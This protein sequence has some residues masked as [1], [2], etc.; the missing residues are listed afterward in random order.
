MDSPGPSSTH[1]LSY[2]P[3]TDKQAKRFMQ[4]KNHCES[5]VNIG[6]T[7]FWLL[8]EISNPNN[9]TFLEKLDM[10]RTELKK[11]F[12][13]DEIMQLDKGIKLDD[14]TKLDVSMLH[15]LVR[16]IC[17]LE[18]NDI[19]FHDDIKSLKDSRNFIAHSADNTEFTDLFIWQN[20]EKLR[21]LFIRILIRIN[22]SYC[23]DVSDNKRKVNKHVDKVL[24]D[25]EVDLKESQLEEFK[26]LLNSGIQCPVNVKIEIKGDPRP[27]SELDELVIRLGRESTRVKL[28]IN[29]VY[30][31]VSELESYDSREHILPLLDSN[32]CKLVWYRGNLSNEMICMLPPSLEQLYI[33]V[34]PNQIESLNNQFPKLTK[35]WSLALYMD[36]IEDID[37]YHMNTVDPSTLPVL[38]FKRKQF[39][40]RICACISTDNIAWIVA[41]IKRLTQ[42]HQCDTLEFYK[43]HLNT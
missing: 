15:K 33:R 12:N 7:I 8:L 9:I 34:R 4:N 5:T 24:K 19:A 3:C 37:L 1:R 30:F 38:Q 36:F 20:I 40:I 18:E 11:K 2:S 13:V 42:E 21:N 29:K 39:G 25:V 27:C 26:N 14:L 41:V 6:K 35:L 32:T 23:T 22:N 43:T 31:D 28:L 10:S 17:K 16:Y